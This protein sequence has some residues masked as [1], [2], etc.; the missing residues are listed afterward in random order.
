MRY[1]WRKTLRP[2]YQ[3]KPFAYSIR[4]GDHAPEGIV[5]IRVQNSPLD[6]VET[7]VAGGRSSWPMKCVS[8]SPLHY[9]LFRFALD[10]A[11]NIVFTGEKYIHGWLTQQ[12][13]APQ[14]R[15]LLLVLLLFSLSPSL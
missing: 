6:L 8:A 7:F 10:A 3:P 14:V 9:F 4:R 15:F 1:H 13:D 2:E 5:S 12:F 11:T